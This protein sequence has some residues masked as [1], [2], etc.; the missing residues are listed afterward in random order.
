MAN[1]NNNPQPKGN[2]LTEFFARTAEA[3]SGKPVQPHAEADPHAVSL[4]I[5]AAD[6][7]NPA[8]RM[9]VEHGR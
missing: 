4:G 5:G 2:W 7:H 8:V 1:G 6:A 3:W 9:E